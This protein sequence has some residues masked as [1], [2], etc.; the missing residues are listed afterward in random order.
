M[1]DALTSLR[2]QH[3]YFLC[4]YPWFALFVTLF[5]ACDYFAYLLGFRPYFL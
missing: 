1:A 2:L 3:L 4:L 5:S